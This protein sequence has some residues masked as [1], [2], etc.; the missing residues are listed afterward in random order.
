MP[1]IYGGNIYIYIEKK[2]PSSESVHVH[3]HGFEKGEAI[4][5][6]KLWRT[7]VEEKKSGEVVASNGVC[8]SLA[9][10]VPKQIL[11]F[12]KLCPST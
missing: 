8:V 2:G 10:L 1:L 12:T 9:F 11:L 4:V 3:V 5:R 6:K 7:T